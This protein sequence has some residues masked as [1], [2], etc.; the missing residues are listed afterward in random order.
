MRRR[1]ALLVA[2]LTVLDGLV[3][4]TFA[5]TGAAHAQ[6]TLSPMGIDERL[7][8]TV[9]LDLTLVD[10]AGRKVTLGSL[11]DRPTILTLNYF[12]CVG[13]C[14]PQLNGVADLMGRIALEPGRDFR[15]LTVSFD[16]RDTPEIAARKRENLLRVIKRPVSP[17]AWR[18]LTGDAASTKALADSVGFAFQR[19]EDGYVHP[20]VII[21]LTAKGQ[22]SRYILGTHFLPADVQMAVQD[23]ARGLSRPTIAQ[24][25]ENCST[26]QPRGQVYAQRVVRLV[27]LGTLAGIG[28]VVGGLVLRGRGLR[29]GDGK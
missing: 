29:K 17:T 10:E 5:A 7:G 20:G 6:G 28:L 26:T 15:V 27:G 9:P 1:S 21:V 23:A 2:V 11:I 24:L 18:L 13:L 19:V 25:P 22:V 12:T 16:P 3:L 4:A 8:A 14:T